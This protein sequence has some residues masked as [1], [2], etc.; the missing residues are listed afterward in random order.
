MF[1]DREV[2]KNVQNFNRFKMEVLKSCCLKGWKFVENGE[3]EIVFRKNYI[4]V[5]FFEFGKLVLWV[6]Y[7]ERWVEEGKII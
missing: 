3:K 1:L 2:L 4:V 7:M 5:S 6:K